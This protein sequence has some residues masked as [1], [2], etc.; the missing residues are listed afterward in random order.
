MA[1]RVMHIA[2][3]LSRFAD[4]LSALMPEMYSGSDPTELGKAWREATGELDVAAFNVAH[5]AVLL[6]ARVKRAD[7]RVRDASDR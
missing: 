6:E 7:E 1:E 3:H 5:L 4:E 2:N